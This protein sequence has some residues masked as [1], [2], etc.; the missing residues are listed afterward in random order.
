VKGLAMRPAGA[1]LPRRGPAAIAAAL[2]FSS[3]GCSPPPETPPSVVIVSLDT[4]RAD[5]LSGYGY[6]RHT[7]PE[8][9]AFAAQGV[10]FLEARC[11]SVGTLTSHL[12]LLTSLHPAH[13][14]ITRAD[15]RNVDMFRTGLRLPEEALT[16]AEVLRA[17]GYETAAFTGGG[18]VAAKWGFGQGFDVYD[19]N[20]TRFE[21][22]RET[23]PRLREYLARRAG[24]AAGRGEAARP[25]FLFVHTYDIHEP[26]SASA[27]G[28]AGKLF[29]NESFYELGLRLGYRP[30]PSVLDGMIDS[31]EP[32]VAGE[33]S[34]LYDN[35]VRDADRLVGELFDLLEAHGLF[36]EAIVVVLSDHGEEFLDHG[37]F[38][39]GPT[40]Y[41]ELVRVPLLVR[42]PGA[43]RFGGLVRAPVA[44]LDVAPT[45]IALCGLAPVP[46]FQGLSLA[47][48][49]DGREPDEGRFRERGLLLDVPSKQDGVRGLWRER[50]KLVA[51]GGG[52]EL[53]DLAADPGERA[54]VG[55]R[56][57]ALRAEL[58]AE[59]EAREREAERLGEER[60]WAARMPADSAEAAMPAEL[61]EQLEALG[62]T[63]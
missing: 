39:H 27:P 1:R 23:L 15:D 51:R 47:G 45:L 53:Y 42:L 43:R 41:E 17:H 60:G 9:D 4:L 37:R 18:F 61:R 34:N 58:A 24:R 31:L 29:S 44:L 8:L 63:R 22:L 36:E 57:A 5:R 50:W 6:P 2:L 20:R 28:P 62:Y 35:G 55:A 48:L 49:V 14:R 46:E 38:N 26:Y 33:L 13:F 59:L 12:S 40:V 32:G 16:L 30:V 56:E 11:Q 10:C 19:E 3:P 25:L 7:S 54:D 21:G 52:T